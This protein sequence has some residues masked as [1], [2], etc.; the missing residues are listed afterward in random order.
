MCLPRATSLHLPWSLGV[1]ASTFSLR[2]QRRHPGIQANLLDKLVRLLCLATC[3][4]L[5]HLHFGIRQASERRKRV[6]FVARKSCGN[7]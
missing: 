6:V 1:Q 5:A 7:T 2:P 4:Q 3:L